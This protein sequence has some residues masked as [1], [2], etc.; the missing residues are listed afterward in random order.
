MADFFKINPNEIKVIQRGTRILADNV[1]VSENAVYPIQTRSKATKLKIK[2]FL[3]ALRVYD[4][5]ENVSLVFRIGKYYELEHG[6]SIQLF[7]SSGFYNA[8]YTCTNNDGNG[9]FNL[10][11]T[12]EHIPDKE[13]TAYLSNINLEDSFYTPDTGWTNPDNPDNLNDEIVEETNPGLPPDADPDDFLVYDAVDGPKW[14]PGEETVEF[15]PYPQVPDPDNLPEPIEARRGPVNIDGQ[16]MLIDTD[17]FIEPNIDH[18][19]IYYD[20]DDQSPTF[21]MMKAKGGGGGSGGIDFSLDEQDTGLKWIDGKNIFCQ[22]FENPPFTGA[23]GPVIDKLIRIDGVGTASDG[24]SPLLP[25]FFS[26]TN[27]ITVSR[28]NNTQRLQIDQSGWSKAS[29]T[30]YYTKP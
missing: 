14:K 21:G 15:L 5:V 29:F 28:N 26:A 10:A 9:L 24:N 23:F 11:L 25:F 17:G 27:R 3:D 16:K 4:F 1:A 2:F 18:D 30:A 6:E 13:L 20:D 7:N 19:T 8:Q 22:T 12:F